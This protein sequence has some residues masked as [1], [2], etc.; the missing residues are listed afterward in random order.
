[1]MSTFGREADLVA[2]ERRE[3]ERATAAHANRLRRAIS[4]AVRTLED[5]D[6]TDAVARQVALDALRP[7]RP[8]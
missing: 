8:V 5:K 7:W 6:I 4:F 1:M 2:K 3:S